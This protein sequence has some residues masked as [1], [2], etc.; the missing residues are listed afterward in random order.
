MPIRGSPAF[1]LLAEREQLHA[2]PVAQE[3]M[4]LPAQRLGE[5]KPRVTL[6]QGRPAGK[7]LRQFSGSHAIQETPPPSTGE[8]PDRISAED[9]LPRRHDGVRRALEEPIRAWERP[10]RV[11]PGPEGAMDR[12]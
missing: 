9:T 10:T 12:A 8:W 5:Q 4:H 1:R 2:E 6:Q 7:V 3:I 11:G